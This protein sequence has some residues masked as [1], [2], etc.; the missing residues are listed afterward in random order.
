ML[1]PTVIGQIQ[2]VAPRDLYKAFSVYVPV[3]HDAV[4]IVERAVEIRPLV[5]T[6]HVVFDPVQVPVVGWSREVSD[7]LVATQ[8]TDPQWKVYV[9][10]SYTILELTDAQEP[11]SEVCNMSQCVHIL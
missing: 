11:Y 6:E 8:Y 4:R 1:F 3:V 5:A 9:V 2:T 10:H 7:D